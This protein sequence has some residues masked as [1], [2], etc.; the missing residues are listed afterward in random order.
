MPHWTA[1]RRARQVE[2]LRTRFAQTEGLPFAD[3]LSAERVAQALVEEKACWPEKIYTPLLTLWA[4]LG[5]VI[6]ADASCRAAVAR[7]L[8]W[9]VSAG[10]PPG[11]PKTDPYCKARQ[12]LPE[13]LLQRLLRETGQT[14]HQH[15]LATWR[16]HGRCVKLADGTT[17]SM[18][19]TPANQQAYPQPSSQRPGLGFPLARLVVV[20]CL[21]TG[22]VLEAALGP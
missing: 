1:R 15:A 20:F 12:R 17:V 13:P 7:V 21:A 3:V 8:A 16:W 22:S 5:Q 9:R 19:D 4:F 10:E 18:P 11:T 6:S 14:L 2:L